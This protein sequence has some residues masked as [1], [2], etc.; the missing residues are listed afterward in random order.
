M[1]LDVS[2]DPAAKQQSIQCLA[3]AK[4]ATTGSLEC[5]PVRWQ[6]RFAGFPDS[7]LLVSRSSAI[8]TPSKLIGPLGSCGLTG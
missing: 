7:P 8:A 5:I 4:A 6:L 1:A 3:R 2:T